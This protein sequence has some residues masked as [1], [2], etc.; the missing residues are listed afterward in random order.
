MKFAKLYETSV[1]QILVV[2]RRGDEG[3]EI[4]FTFDMEPY[5]LGLCEVKVGYSDSDAD[6]DKAQSMF[7]WITEAYASSV[8]ADKIQSIKEMLGVEP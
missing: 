7:D 8:V 1:G 4:T 6:G 2:L 5:G 3:H